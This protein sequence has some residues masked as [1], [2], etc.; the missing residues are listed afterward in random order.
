MAN[1]ITDF[2][3]EKR[4]VM[5]DAR[6]AREP[7]TGFF[8]GWSHIRVA[9]YALVTDSGANI[10][11][12]P[13]WAFGVCAGSTNIMGD[14]TTDHFCGAISN[15]GTWT[16]T[17]GPPT[18]YS[19]SSL[20]VPA[21]KVVSTLTTGTAFSGAAVFM[22]T[23]TLGMYF[24]DI[25]KGS[26]DYSLQFFRPTSTPSPTL[27]DFLTQSVAT[28]PAFTNHA[29]STAQTVAVDEATDGTFDHGCVWWDQA[30]CNVNIAAW[31]MY[32]IA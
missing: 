26:P 2:S 1:I 3:G 19:G 29:Y 18:R 10:T 12:T 22:A 21:K 25:I 20:W 28:I 7:L 5:T 24:I 17:A 9:L 14:A 6:F 11:G 8:T 31:R 13:R 32:R 4:V 27:S 16:R 23:A 30:V 15:L